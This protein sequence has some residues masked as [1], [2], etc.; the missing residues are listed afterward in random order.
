MQLLV[1]GLVAELVGKQDRV[2]ES[3]EIARFVQLLAN[4]SLWYSCSMRVLHDDDHRLQLAAVAMMMA[5]QVRQAKIAERLGCTA[6]H[7]SRLVKEAKA[8]GLLVVETKFVANGITSEEVRQ[9]RERYLPDGSVVANLSGELSGRAKNAGVASFS[10][11]V[12]SLQGRRHAAR[13]RDRLGRAAGPHVVNL[14]ARA[15]MCGVSWGDTL[16]AVARALRDVAGRKG[17]RPRKRVQFLPVVGEPLGGTLT[18]TSSSSL[19]QQ[20]SDI[21][22]EGRAPDVPSLGSVPALVPIDLTPD[23]A[24]GVDKVIGCVKAYAHIFGSAKSVRRPLIEKLDAILT[25]VSPSKLPLGMA[26]AR[27]LISAGLEREK[28]RKLAIGDISGVLLPN[29]LAAEGALMKDLTSAWKG[30]KEEHV[31][32]CALRAADHGAPGVIVV[33]FGKSKAMTALAAVE[34]GLVNHLL[35]DE[36]LSDEIG[37]LLRSKAR[38]KVA[39]GEMLV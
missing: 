25:S 38:S 14:L 16:L 29:Q 34:R 18:S 23:Q 12:L 27:Y 19:A 7:V 11:V 13:S 28:L 26:G 8:T 22:N 35:I 17:P 20:L 3:A 32:A 1:E 4:D 39:D 15:S 37:K 36:E 33:A 5:R 10:V 31:R 21:L 30:I 9:A 24:S 6:G 2:Q